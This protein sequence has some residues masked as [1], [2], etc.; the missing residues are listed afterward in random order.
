MKMASVALSCFQKATVE[1]ICQCWY[2]EIAALALF[3]ITSRST[4]LQ[5]VL[6]TGKW[7]QKTVSVNTSRL[8]KQNRIDKH[9]GWV[10]QQLQ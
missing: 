5:P 6:D 2:D 3:P 10:A 1:E 8:A 7:N 9:L 4:V